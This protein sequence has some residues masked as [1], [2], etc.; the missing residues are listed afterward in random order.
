MHILNLAAKDLLFGIDINA[1]EFQDSNSLDAKTEE[2]E[3]LKWIKT[4]PVCTARNLVP[5]IHRS[6]QRKDEFN[7]VQISILRW[8]D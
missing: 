4:E 5:F 3:F 1:F 6:R 8:S 2:A 7:P